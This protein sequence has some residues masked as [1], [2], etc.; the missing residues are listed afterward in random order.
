MS[1][2]DEKYVSTNVKAGS[3]LYDKN[4]F[5]SLNSKLVASH[6]ELGGFSHAIIVSS[7]HRPG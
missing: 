2:W 6:P 1:D 7:P 5:I 4:L 3:R